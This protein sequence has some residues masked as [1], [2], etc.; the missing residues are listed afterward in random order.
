MDGYQFA[1]QG[2]ETPVL[3]LANEKKQM[4]EETEDFFD[5]SL[6]QGVC[7]L[8]RSQQRGAHH[9]FRDQDISIPGFHSGCHSAVVCSKA[10]ANYESVSLSVARPFSPSQSG[11]QKPEALSLISFLL[12][13]DH[14]R[15]SRG[16]GF[17]F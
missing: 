12:S 2:L 17:C 6:R 11:N 15:G 1:A 14:I 9:I 8:G 16:L 5:A 13:G 4:L 3:H 10:V 7:S